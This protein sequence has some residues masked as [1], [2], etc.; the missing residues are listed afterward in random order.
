[1]NGVDKKVRN[2]DGEEEPAEDPVEEMMEIIGEEKGGVEAALEVVPV[3]KPIRERK[4]EDIKEL[5]EK[6]ELPILFT[7]RREELGG[8]FAG[9]MEERIGIFKLLLDL[10]PAYMDFEMEYLN[11][12]KKYLALYNN[13][14]KKDIQIL[15]TSYNRED[16]FS[17]DE[18]EDLYDEMDLKGPD[19]FSFSCNIS[20]FAHMAN[21]FAYSNDMKKRGMM[22]TFRGMGKLKDKC[23]IFAPLLGSSIA[24]CTAEARKKRGKG[25]I[26]IEELNEQWT[27]LLGSVAMEQI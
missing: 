10:S 17:E 22:Y 25:L 26:D 18:M 11:A 1:M 4:V 21:L 27:L 16:C 15:V 23:S 3:V 24:F 14:R 2:S 20:T 12:D 19:F 13:A 7:L 9:D 6:S 5:R 8:R